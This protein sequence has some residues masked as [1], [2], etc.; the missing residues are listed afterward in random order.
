[1]W[2]RSTARWA[3]AARRR[4][5]RAD[6]RGLPRR[7][8]RRPR[9]VRQCPAARRPGAR[10]STARGRAAGVTTTTRS[11]SRRLRQL[12]AYF[13]G[14][15]KDFDLPLAPAGTPFQ[16]RVWAALRDIGYGETS[17]VRRDRRRPRPDRPRRPRGRAWR[18]AATR[19]RSS[20]RATASSAPRAALTGYGGGMDRKQTLLELEQDALSDA[21]PPRDSRW[22]TPPPKVATGPTRLRAARARASGRFGGGRG[23]VSRRGA[24]S[25]RAGRRRRGRRGRAC[26]RAGG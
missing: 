20:C 8:A 19:C 15:L 24:A 21:E 18:T 22:S 25:R 5:R 10:T 9:R 13:A 4:G 23:S 7:D 6:G 3:A 26:G 1:M 12:A 17:D 11:W 16:Q 14:D 2:T